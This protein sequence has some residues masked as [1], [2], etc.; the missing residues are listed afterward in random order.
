MRSCSWMAIGVLTG[1]ACCGQSLS[2]GVIGGVRGTDDLTGPGA[3]SASKRYAVGPALDIGL[4]RGFGLEADALYR[5]E[6]YHS[7]F[8]DCSLHCLWRSQ[9]HLR[10]AREFMGVSDTGQTQASISRSH[11]LSGT[12]LCAPRDSRIDQHDLR[13][14]GPG[15]NP[16]PSPALDREHA[17]ACQPWRRGWRGNSVRVRPAALLARGSLHAVDQQPDLAARPR[18]PGVA[19]RAKPGGRATR[20]SLEDSIDRDGFAS[21]LPRG[22]GGKD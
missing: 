7:F 21:I 3:T 13:G 9:R 11:A 14:F 22:G 20:R 5:R 19:I 16:L 10:G 8:F 4:P 6:G 2:I 15:P 12:G 1:C 18:I 17:L